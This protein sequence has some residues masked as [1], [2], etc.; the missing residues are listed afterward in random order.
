MQ[1][2]RP[3]WPWAWL[4]T[5]LD[6]LTYGKLALQSR[7]AH[8]DPA[9][10]DALL[11]SLGT[12]LGGRGYERARAKLSDALSSLHSEIGDDP[13]LA[14]LGCELDALGESYG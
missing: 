13:I 14:R 12:A 5:D 1:H 10:A 11:A 8:E 7:R 9:A 6:P 3:T 2:A 4:A